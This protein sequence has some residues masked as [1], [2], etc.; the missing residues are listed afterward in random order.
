MDTQQQQGIAALQRIH[1]YDSD[2]IE[3]HIHGPEVYSSIDDDVLNDP[4]SGL[5]GSIPE[6]PHS[7]DFQR[8][9]ITES[10]KSDDDTIYAC[11]ELSV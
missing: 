5:F 7:S 3:T 11:S 8:V 4:R 9:V 2:P 1:V 10:G 6:Y